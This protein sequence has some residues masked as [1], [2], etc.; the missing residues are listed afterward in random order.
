MAVASIWDAVLITRDPFD[1][2][3][4]YVDARKYIVINNQNVSKSIALCIIIVFVFIIFLCL[5]MATGLK[6]AAILPDS[7]PGQDIK[8]H[9]NSKPPWLSLN[10][11]PKIQT[12]CWH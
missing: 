4:N 12:E 6:H 5:S 2:I 9:P 1:Y 10:D 3:S 11:S 7:C 8:R